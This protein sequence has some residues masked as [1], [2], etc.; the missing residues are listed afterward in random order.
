[1]GVVRLVWSVTAF[2]AVALTSAVMLPIV[3]NAIAYALAA[4]ARRRF[5]SRCPDDEGTPWASRAHG[6]V[7][8]CAAIW[9]PLGGLLSTGR[10]ASTES[11]TQHVIV[12]HTRGAPIRRL[13]RRL[14][15]AGFTPHPV[16]CSRL[17]GGIETNATQLGIVLERVHGMAGTERVDIVAHGLG[18]LVARA[19]L[20]RPGSAVSVGRLVTLGTPHEGTVA[21]EWAGLSDGEALPPRV[22]LV[23]IFSGDDALV[24]P[25]SRA[26]HPDAFNIEV[27]GVGHLS[28]LVSARVFELV[29]ENLVDEDDA[30][31]SRSHA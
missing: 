10:R 9:L 14:T 26:H 1:M 20:R 12:V 28:L 15:S 23:S 17:L 2:L 22:E 3:A 8:E 27:A 7:T 19:Y 11:S 4:R 29:R 18:G 21:R 30:A 24:V 25:P 5:G 6:F 31:P 16:G 13:L